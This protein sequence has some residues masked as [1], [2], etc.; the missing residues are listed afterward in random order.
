MRK[1]ALAYV[2]AAMSFAAFAQ[3]NNCTSPQKCSLIGFSANLTNFTKPLSI[4][5][6]FKNGNSSA[7]FSIMYWRGINRNLDFTFRYNGLF[8]NYSKNPSPSNSSDYGNELESDVHG[9]LLADNKFVQPFVTTG[10]GLAVYGGKWGVFVPLGGG[11]QFNFEEITYLFLHMS[12]RATLT[13]SKLDNSLFYS[14]GIAES[15]SKS[16]Y[17][18][19]KIQ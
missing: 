14:L 11:I 16:R 3:D 18:R 9:R 19:P 15:I 10:L 17:P 8:T 2:S 7:G 1:L 12:Y 6:S 5:N 13:S 4:G